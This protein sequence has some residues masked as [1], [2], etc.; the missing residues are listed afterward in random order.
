MGEFDTKKCISYGQDLI[1][2]LR[3]N[4]DANNS[5]QCLEESKT[6]RS[7]CKADFAE[8]KNLLE[9]YQEK[10]DAHKK[11][12]AEA[13]S[14]ESLDNVENQLEEELEKRCSLIKELR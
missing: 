13:S 3:S 5:V 14:D 10:I 1:Q 7:F 2:V 6:L 8:V 11:T 12:I 4:N 9:D